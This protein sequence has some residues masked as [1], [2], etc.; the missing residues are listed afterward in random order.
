VSLLVQRPDVSEFRRRFRWLFLFVFLAFTAI[1]VRVVQLQLVHSA[2]YQAIAKENVVRRVTLATERGVMRDKDGEVL[3]ASREAFNLYVVPLRITCAGKDKSFACPEVKTP[4][5]KPEMAPQW[6]KLS[7]W[8]GMSDAEREELEQKLLSIRE[9]AGAR[10]HQQILLREDVSR[11]VV[12]TLRTHSHE[13]PGVEVV[14]VSVRY[15]KHKEVGA[16][17]LGY[18]REVDEEMI[19]NLRKKG[20]IEGD[21]VGATGLEKA[22][23]S[24]LRG[25]RGWEKVVVDARGGVRKQQEGEDIIDEPAKLDPIP[26][27]DLRLTID[28]DIQK[29]MVK[30]MSGEAAGGAALVDVRSGRI[31]GLVSKPSYDPNELSGG[32]GK[33]KVR[34]AFRRLY[35]NNLKPAVDK[36][37]SGAYPPGSTFKPFTALTALEMGL[38]D[39]HRR[40]NCRGFLRFGRR[41][42]RC[43]SS[44]GSVDLH[45]AI[46]QSCNVYF[47][48][49]VT[50]YGVQMDMIAERGITYGFGKKTGLGINA[51]T[52]GRMPTRAWM[53]LRNKGQFRHGFTVNAAIG[54]GATTVSVLQLALAYA[55]LANGGTLYQPQLV[56]AVETAAGEVVQEF[57]PRVRRRIKLDGQHQKIIADALWAGVNEEGGTSNRA[58]IA[59]VDAS[60]KTGSAQ[61]SHKFIPG[62]ELEN[63]WYFNRDHAW[64]AGYAPSRNPEVAIVVLIEHGGAGGK[65]AAPVAFE[66]LKAYQEIMATERAKA[67]QRRANAGATP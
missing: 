9:T 45:K 50:D 53:T 41:L 27:R 4:R 24:Y 49:L 54:Q 67:G 33:Q 62:Q 38:I 21:R 46:A 42:F 32:Y 66:I 29:A 11:D 44:H 22:W 18:M 52:S 64:F 7:E 57:S 1:G 23:E 60:G 25:A 28:I 58:R 59:G 13:L 65:H 43:T 48:S 35:N 56:N 31:L 8:I 19:V 16:H 40:T 37:V 15:Y 3:A 17:V 10:V 5:A 26:G 51:E 20:Y 2:D 14:A 34:D 47:Y 63:I 30:A 39:P 12:A 6:S 36:T 61:V 55:A